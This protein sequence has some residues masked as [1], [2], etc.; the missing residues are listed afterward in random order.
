MPKF[1]K[2]EQKIRK[3]IKK[4]K[5]FVARIGISYPEA[6]ELINDTPEKLTLPCHLG[7][8]FYGDFTIKLFE[9]IK[10]YLNLI[11]DSFFFEIRNLGLFSFSKEIYSRGIKK[12]YKELRKSNKKLS[13]HPT[14][15]FYQM[16]ID[17]RTEEK[18]GMIIA[19]TD[20]PI[21]SS[22]EVNILFL[23]GETHLKHRA[24][25]VS[26][27]KLKE[28]FY[29]RPNDQNL[30]FQRLIKEV[31]HEIGHIILGSE[32]CKENSCV[33]KFSETIE[34]IDEKSYRFCSTCK[35]NLDNVRKLFNF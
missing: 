24:S 26:T 14:N 34:E 7:I 21:Y 12:E 30:F 17:K 15:K 5:K 11:Y 25:I 33:M 20:L 10:S 32:H 3:N 2:Y 6:I 29:S 28:R 4:L 8:L 16:L 18:L 9:Q 31:I 13:I 19:L 35:G 23:F 22:T 1:E 27:L